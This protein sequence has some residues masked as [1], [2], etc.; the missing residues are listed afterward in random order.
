LVKHIL[1]TFNGKIETIT[2]DETSNT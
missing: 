1:D 2:S